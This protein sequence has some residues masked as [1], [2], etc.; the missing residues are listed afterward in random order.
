MDTNNVAIS[1]VS[2][3]V[4]TCQ[5]KAS[6]STTD[7]ASNWQSSSLCGEAFDRTQNDSS[8]SVMLI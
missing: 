2:S 1:V 4:K 3:R 5:T 8:H 7:L 6:S